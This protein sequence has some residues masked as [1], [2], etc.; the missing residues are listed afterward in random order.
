MKEPQAV[1]AAGRADNSSMEP[2]RVYADMMLH[3]VN[4]DPQF[5]MPRRPR[6]HAGVVAVPFE[7]GLLLEGTAE[8]RV[9]GGAAA[10]SLLPRLLPLLDGTR[11]LADLIGVIGAD[12]ADDV[13]A[14]LAL[15]YT[16]GHVQ[17]A[18]TDLGLPAGVSTGAAETVGRLLDTTRVWP[19]VESAFHALHNAPALIVDTG[20]PAARL[21]SLLAASGDEVRSIP[22]DHTPD[23]GQFIIVASSGEED[24]DLLDALDRRSAEAGATWLRLHHRNGIL[25]MGPLFDRRHTPCFACFLAA[26]GTGDRE[27]VAA[28]GDI[29]D[30]LAWAMAAGEVFNQRARIGTSLASTALAT[31]DLR[32]WTARQESFARRP[33]CERCGRSKL[34]GTATPAFIYDQGVAF[35]PRDK[36]SPKGHQVHYRMDNLMIQHDHRSYDSSPKISLPVVEPA[37]V[38]GRAGRL[39]VETLGA[40]LRG[41]FGL[42]PEPHNPQV[43]RYAPTGGNLGSPQAFLIVND[44]AGIAAGR[45][46]YNPFEHCLSVL[47]EEPD[48][49]ERDAA[50]VVSIHSA[51]SRVA[52]KYQQLAFRICCL[53]AGVA[54]AQLEAIAADAGIRAS[55]LDAWDDD[56]LL[57]AFDLSREGNPVTAVVTLHQSDTEAAR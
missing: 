11:T 8:R 46:Y 15:L 47:G 32:R 16:S 39:D 1:M 22:I 27:D 6:L 45:Y 31:I 56:E 37:A 3:A 26:R 17:E 4:E 14:A 40:L 43:R 35:P 24:T 55:I 49:V 34:G 53:D 48:P 23:T 30:D 50:V 12:R 5:S 7:R 52:H 2:H 20:R 25:E 33:E 41:A 51:L 44:V 28:D 38:A 57:S 21:A 10:R 13:S 36:I 42:K 54:C 18:D 9:F 29:F 19:N